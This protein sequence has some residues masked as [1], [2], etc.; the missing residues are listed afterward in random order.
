MNNYYALLSLDPGC[1]EDEIRKA[2]HRELRTWT[3]RTNA[4]DL[5]RK[6][7]AERRIKLLDEADAILLDPAKSANYDRE[8]GRQP[9]V[10]AALELGET[11]NPAEEARRLLEDGRVAD[12]LY[13]AQKASEADRRDPD[14]W[15]I[16]G[17]ANHE[18][19]ETDR[20]VKCLKRAISIRPDQPQYQFDLGNIYE[21]TQDWPSAA[22][23]SEDVL[24]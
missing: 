22:Q 10:E 21:S 24:R 6:Q 4:P 5:Q 7:E 16:L 2:I 20:A 8:L 1:A 18:F 19:G 3:N 17:R 14:I 12:A 23:C 13:L 15:W 11:G 9:K